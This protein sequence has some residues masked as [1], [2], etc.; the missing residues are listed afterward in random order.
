MNHKEFFFFLSCQQLRRKRESN[1]KKRKKQK[2]K[3]IENTEGA[4]FRL[5]F[6]Q[7]YKLTTLVSKI[8]NIGII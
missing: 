3:K 5:F 2:K 8:I 6:Y 4:L 7:T 1:K